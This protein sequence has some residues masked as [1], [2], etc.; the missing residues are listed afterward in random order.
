[1][2]KRPTAIAFGSDGAVVVADKA[3]EVHRFTRDPHAGGL[4]TEP[5]FILG[6]VSVIM[7]VAMSEDGSLILTVRHALCPCDGAPPCP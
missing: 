2:T 1:M 6:H 4:A 3:G 7:A 5:E